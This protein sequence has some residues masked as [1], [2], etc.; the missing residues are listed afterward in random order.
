[1]LVNTNIH[2]NP[3]ILNMSSKYLFTLTVLF[4]THLLV[5]QTISRSNLATAGGVVSSTS[6][7]TLSWS[8]GEVFSN[9]VQ[10]DNHITGGFQQGNL[11]KKNIPIDEDLISFEPEQQSISANDN[12]IINDLKIIVF[13]NPTADQLW[14]KFNATDTPLLTLKIIDTSGKIF[15]QNK[16]R[17]ENSQALEINQI[18]KLSSGQYTLFLYDNQSVVSSKQ[19]IKL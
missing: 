2:K 11:L 16:V 7:M 8:I 12:A 5:G 15:I 6:G 19:F 17:F 4:F 13:P 10:E 1:M 18:N 14:L 3:K 9:T